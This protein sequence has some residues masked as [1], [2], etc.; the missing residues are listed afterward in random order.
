MSDDVPVLTPQLFLLIGLCAVGSLAH[1]IPDDQDS[2]ELAC[3]QAPVSSAPTLVLRGCDSGVKNRQWRECTIDDLLT[4]CEQ[5]EA[6]F[7]NRC[8]AKT[9]NRLVELDIID[10]K[11]KGEIQLCADPS[12]FELG[13]IHH[14]NP[15]NK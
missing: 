3:S 4:Q 6:Q 1:A 12:D 9:T 5:E 7:R 8:I 10:G 14:Q 2:I 13:D 15:G 11:E